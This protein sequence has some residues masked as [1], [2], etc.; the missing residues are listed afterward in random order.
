[1]ARPPTRRHAG[2]RLR[3]S[4]TIPFP[5]Q[6]LGA[7]LSPSYGFPSWSEETGL[8]HNADGSLVPVRTTSSAK[9]YKIKLQDPKHVGAFARFHLRNPSRGLGACKLLLSKAAEKRGR[10]ANKAVLMAG[11]LIIRATEPIG[12]AALSRLGSLSV[13]SNVIMLDENADVTFGVTAYPAWVLQM[14]KS[15][16]L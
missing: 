7:E 10:K 8:K 5:P 1:M 2:S 4:Q 11:P 15:R 16:V 6:L 9:T 3:A 12:T 14:A 13:R